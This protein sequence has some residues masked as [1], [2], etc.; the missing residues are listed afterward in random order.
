MS[1]PNRHV[2]ETAVNGDYHATQATRMR[3]RLIVEP[4][5][6][7]RF[8]TKKPAA[9]ATATGGDHTYREQDMTAETSMTQDAD[10]ATV[11]AAA[12]EGF[13]RAE[14]EHPGIKKR[15]AKEPRE[16]FR[17][18]VFV[19]RYVDDAA[20]ER[21]NPYAEGFVAGVLYEREKDRDLSATDVLRVLLDPEVR[22]IIGPLT[23]DELAS[24]AKHLAEGMAAGSRTTG[25]DL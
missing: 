23:T 25:E 18:G 15:A 16:A 8:D 19:G 6:S 11:R 9:A 5:G 2:I 22:D 17:L 1:R 3:E 4:D 20:T 12:R 10:E 7:V 13:E 21:V 24:L 14:A